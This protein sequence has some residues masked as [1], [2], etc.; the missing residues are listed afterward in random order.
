MSLL[1]LAYLGAAILFILS[2]SGLSSQD[3]ARRGNV[4][5]IIGMV[6]ALAA[7]MLHKEVSSYEVTAHAALVGTIL[8]GSIIGFIW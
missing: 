4:Y 3:S 8:V 7:T 1:T 6:I 5:G 2:L